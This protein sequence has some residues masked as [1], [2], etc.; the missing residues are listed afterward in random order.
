MT[1]ITQQVSERR[2]HQGPLFL[3]ESYVRGQA[4]LSSDDVLA[5]LA[6]MAYIGAYAFPDVNLHG[7]KQRMLSEIQVFLPPDSEQLVDRAL[8]V[9]KVFRRPWTEPGAAG[10]PTI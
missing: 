4:G 2:Y 5:T 6:I 8:S 7:L 3:A 9:A 10:E 1:R